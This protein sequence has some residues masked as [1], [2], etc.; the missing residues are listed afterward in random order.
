MRADVGE[1][2]GRL[3][4]RPTNERVEVDADHGGDLRARDRPSLRN[5]AIFGRQRLEGG[6]G[7]ERV[8][9]LVPCGAWIDGHRPAERVGGLAGLAARLE[10]AAEQSERIGITTIQFDCLP[11]M[12]LG[13]VERASRELDGRQFAH[14]DWTGRRG[15]QGA[16]QDR[17]RLV[18]PSGRAGPGGRSHFGLGD[19][20]PNQI[21]TAS[22][23]LRAK[24]PP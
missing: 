13:R 2:D 22:A 18:Q 24:D 21:Q 12:L 11:G 9:L 8:A 16:F 19:A 10:H 5:A 7:A 1:D 17:L 20:Q 4:W 6:A 3:A 23:P 14:H 15:L